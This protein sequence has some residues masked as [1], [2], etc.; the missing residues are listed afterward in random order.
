MLTLGMLYEVVLRWAGAGLPCLGLRAAKLNPNRLDPESGKPIRVG[1]PD[2]VQVLTVQEDGSCGTYR[3]SGVVWHNTG[4]GIALYG[5]EGTLS[6]DLTRDEIRGARRDESALRLMPIPDGAAGG[7]AGRGR[8]HRGDP[9]RTPRDS[10]GLRHGR[11]LHAVH[12]GRRA[13][14]ASSVARDAPPERVFQPQPLIRIPESSCT[15]RGRRC[16]LW[17]GRP[18]APGGHE[19][20]GKRMRDTSPGSSSFSV[21]DPGCA[22]IPLSLSTSK[23]C[24]GR[25]G[26]AGC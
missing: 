19:L 10:D 25:E 14:L 4:A 17:S 12:R 26:V 22:L 13:E 20:P 21:P 6:Y 15:R 16:S 5:S 9:G 3:I 24:E 11:P 23:R 7:M 18:A 1:S 8:L 2:S